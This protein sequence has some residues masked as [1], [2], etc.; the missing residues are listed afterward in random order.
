VELRPLAS[1]VERWE[2]PFATAF[3]L[4]AVGS[5]NEVVRAEAVESVAADRLRFLDILPT[6]D[7]EAVRTGRSVAVTLNTSAV[8]DRP[9]TRPVVAPSLGQRFDQMIEDRAVRDF[10]EAQPSDSWRRG[11]IT[12]TNAGRYEFRAVTTGFER[13]I[14]ATL[15]PDGAISGMANVPGPADHIRVFDR[16]AGTLPPGI[17]LIPDPPSHAVITDDVVAD[18]VNLPSGRVVADAILNGEVEPLPDAAAPGRYPV[19][20]T[21]VR[22]PD[23]GSDAVAFASL[24]VSDAPTIRWKQLGGIAVDG[25]TAAFTSAEGQTAMGELSKSN[26]AGWQSLLDAGYDSLTAHDDVITEAPITTGLDYVR[27]STGF[28]DGV[29]P[30]HVGLDAAGK[31]TRFVIDFA[32]VHLDWPGS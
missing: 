7:A 13:A 31:P 11:T 5:A 27:F 4:A 24:V 25:G 18:P 22:F 28:G 2:Q 29:Y 10:I 32:I 26:E 17:K 20:V 1:I 19:H 12:A 16:R 9:P 8:L 6:G 30:I 3:G 21:L 23:G 14:T 15:E